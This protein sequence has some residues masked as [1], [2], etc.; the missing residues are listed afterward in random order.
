MH[1]NRMKP[2]A[3]ARPLAALIGAAL[4]V[5]SAMPAFA[6][7]AKVE[8][9]GEIPGVKGKAQ[10]QV[11]VDEGNYATIIA[12]ARVS[13]GKP[14]GKGVLTRAG[15]GV[16]IYVNDEICTADRDVRRQVDVSSFTGKFA[17]SATCMTVLKPGT[18]TILAEKT[19][20]NV[21]GSK[22]GLKYS[23]FGGKPER[24]VGVSQ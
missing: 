24:M 13:G 2:R 23:I 21:E 9:Y 3:V 4:L 16:D 6:Q 14:V 10:A 7:G 11:K 17:T 12:V 22:L 1:D 5:G 18:H 19:E 20:I 15:I 8:E